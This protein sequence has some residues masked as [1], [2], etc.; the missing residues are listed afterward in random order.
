MSQ[1]NNNWY[2]LAHLM[3]WMCYLLFPLFVFPGWPNDGD[4][5]GLTY[6]TFISSFR[7]LMIPFFY[8]NY[9]WAVPECYFQL[10]FKQYS[11]TILFAMSV[12]ICS[13][14]LIVYWV[15]GYYAVDCLTPLATFGIG[16]FHLVFI[17]TISLGIQVFKRWAIW[18]K[19]K[20]R[21]ELSN[22]KMQVNPHFLFNS[23]NNIYTLSILNSDKTAPSIAS[24]S[25]I[26]KYVVYQAKNDFVPLVDEIGYIKDFVELQRIRLTTTSH[27]DFK[28]TGDMEGKSIHPLLFIAFIENAFKYGISTE[29]HTLII[30]HIEINDLEMNLRCENSK[31]NFHESGPKTGIANSVQRL[32][33]IYGKSYYLDI[34]DVGEKFKLHLKI[35][36]K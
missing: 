24:L 2:I 12:A 3:F 17:F 1:W 27:L 34:D 36:L 32:N 31:N 25:S 4:E 22:L 16:M 14:F 28:V 20:L 18:E 9:N 30:I 8:F 26:M 35:P 6:T 29:N 21:L 15:E 13:I 10:K 7:V 33:L 5:Y 11:W 19:E 23:L